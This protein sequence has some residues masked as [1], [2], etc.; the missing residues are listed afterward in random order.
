[1]QVVIGVVLNPIS[2]ELFTTVRGGGAHRNGASIAVTDTA[3]LGSALVATEVNFR[4]CC[5]WRYVGCLKDPTG[6]C[7]VTSGTAELSTMLICT[8]SG[9]AQ[10]RSSKHSMA[11][12][13]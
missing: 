3:D 11:R 4:G 5:G 10:A 12:T 7:S 1:M 2:N 13:A 8:K 6:A 9:S